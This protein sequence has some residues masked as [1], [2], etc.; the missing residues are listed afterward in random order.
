MINMTTRNASSTLFS[1][2]SQTFTLLL[3]E[4]MYVSPLYVGSIFKT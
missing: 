1:T 2:L 3:D 4:S